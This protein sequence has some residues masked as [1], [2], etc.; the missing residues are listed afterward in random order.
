MERP[1][2][3][4]DIELLNRTATMHE[5]HPRPELVFW[6]D[7]PP[8]ASAGVFGF[9]AQEWGSKVFYMC[10]NPLA[11]ERRAAGWVDCNHGD[12]VV[13]ILSEQEGPGQSLREFF[14]EH[15]DVIHVCNGFR[16]L[17]AP[18][19]K[20]Y[21]LPL[22]N[23]RVVVW[24]ERPGVY[25]QGM[26]RL[27]RRIGISALYRYY[28]L[29]YGSRI[30]ALLPLGTLGVE[31]FAAFGWN[32]NIL[33][34][35]MYDPQIQ[36]DLPHAKPRM[37]GQLL[38]LVYV[39]RFARW[40]KGIDILIHAVDGLR[41]DKWRLDL[42]G[43]YGEFRDYAIKW[44]QENPNVRFRGTWPSNEVCQRMSEYDIC[45]VPSRFDGWNVVVN[46]SIHA[47]VG[48]IVTDETV[49]HDLIR[50]SGAGVVVPAGNADALREEIQ[51]VIDDPRIANKWKK[52]AVAYSPRIRSDSVGR[53]LI[54]V[55]D[56]TFLSSTGPRPECPWL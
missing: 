52:K 10:I 41:G 23:A 29:R 50:A 39:G 15:N 42:V 12:A 1:R 6:F 11:Q 34:P 19:I 5:R 56:Y 9:V 51:R 4:P 21:V 36:E 18:Y 43:G 26:K 46:E 49:S 47:G 53:Y 32:R 2:G 7:A 40:T 27:Q 54:D 38:R 55:L 25:G 37:P 24:S 44:A 16:S 31:T 28:A 17:T 48:V 35:F 22:P 14:Q 33:F 45:I 20:R 30:H 13:T 8:R 3:L